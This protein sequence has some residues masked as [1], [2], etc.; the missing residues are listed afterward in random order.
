MMNT[1]P[2]GTVLVPASEYMVV[3]VHQFYIVPMLQQVPN[4]NDY[5]FTMPQIIPVISTNIPNSGTNVPDC[6][7]IQR[8]IFYPTTSIDNFSYTNMQNMN[9][10]Y[11]IH[12]TPYDLIDDDDNETPIYYLSDSSLDTVD[13]DSGSDMNISNISDDDDSDAHHV[14]D[15]YDDEVDDDDDDD[16]PTTGA[17]WL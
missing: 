17:Y 2:P 14:F 16:E 12:D 5:V 11:D 6:N 10:S 4:P 1:L 15:G 7:T 9:S 3:P 8:N 13:L